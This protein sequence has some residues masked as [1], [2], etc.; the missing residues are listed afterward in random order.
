MEEI[1]NDDHLHTSLSV[2]WVV[3][4]ESYVWMEWSVIQTPI[5][6]VVRVLIWFAPLQDAVILFWTGMKYP[7]PYG[8]LLTVVVIYSV[9]KNATYILI[10]NKSTVCR[11]CA[12]GEGC[13]VNQDCYSGKCALNTQNILKWVIGIHIFLNVIFWLICVDSRC[14]DGLQNGDEG[15][16]D[17]GSACSTN[18]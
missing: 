4:R 8:Y 13:R 7:L 9:S 15:D 16:V 11:K 2:V 10:I 18:S 3:W 17:C 1:V 14:D 6:L 12:S 5:V